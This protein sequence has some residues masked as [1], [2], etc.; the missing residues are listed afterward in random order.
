M[1]SAYHLYFISWIIIIIIKNIVISMKITHF[2]SIVNCKKKKITIHFI[3][4][5]Y[6]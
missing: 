5:T 3:L 2:Y 6:S 4:K 1:G